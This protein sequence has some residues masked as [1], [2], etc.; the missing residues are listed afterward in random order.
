[1]PVMM[2]KLWEKVNLWRTSA[3]RVAAGV[4][5][6]GEGAG[7]CET[8]AAAAPITL[9]Q[10]SWALVDA[11]VP[12]AA[13]LHATAEAASS[14]SCCVICSSMWR[15]WYALALCPGVLQQQHWMAATTAC[16]RLKLNVSFAEIR[17]HFAPSAR[18]AARPRP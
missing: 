4:A 7:G 17:Q 18:A 13:E 9:L 5:S 10:E 3:G 1:M 6:L 11:K 15:T 2:R 14:R 8:A 12:A 16:K